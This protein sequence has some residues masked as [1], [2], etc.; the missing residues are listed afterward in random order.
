MSALLASKFGEQRFDEIEEVID[1]LQLAPAVLIELAVARQ[2]VQFLEQ[3]DGLLGL[4]FGDGS[5][6]VSCASSREALI[7]DAMT[8][9]WSNK[10]DNGGLFT[11]S[12]SSWLF[13]GIP[14]T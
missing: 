3:F 7:L 12:D 11:G 4:D 13:S 6:R 8:V 10:W 14:V 5:A 1:L 9:G 2:D